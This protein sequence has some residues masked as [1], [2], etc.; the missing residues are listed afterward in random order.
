MT[1]NQIKT[2]FDQAEAELL[3]VFSRIEKTEEKNLARVLEAF[4]SQRIA[5][6]H[7]AATNGYGNGDI[8]RDGLEKVFAQAFGTQA[9]LVRPMFASGT[10]ALA[11]CLFGLLRPG[12]TMLAVSGRPYDTLESVIGLN[13]NEHGQGSLKEL[14]VR[15]RELKLLDS[16]VDFAALEEELKEKTLRLCHIQR[17]CGYAWRPAL[18]VDEIG[19]IAAFIHECRPDVCVMV[20]N[21]YG[22]FVEEKE[23][24]QVGAD[25]M[26]GS[27]IKN[28]GGGIAPTGGYIAGKAEL[29]E[30]CA[31]RLTAPG[32]GTELGSYA[33][34]YEPFYQGFFLAPHVVAQAVRGAALAGCVF[35]KLGFAV[36]PQ[37]DRPR[38]DIIQAIRFGNE[39]TLIRFCRAIQHASPIDSFVVPEPW[40]MAGY[41]DKV[42]MAAGTFVSGASIELSA[43]APLREPYIGYLQGGLSY[44]H[45]KFALMEAVKSLF[46]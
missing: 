16:G 32:I 39:E 15:Y 42:I 7:F 33:A 2:I 3:P 43:D 30:R 29:V 9:A 12:D 25:I 44:A 6:Q 23:P 22:E 37:P 4:R 21:C 19:R 26:A 17:S 11:V 10:H 18:R 46:A 45:V 13:E 34:G 38:S 8:G 28:P 20:D 27:L 41:Q 24:T 40:D 5:V 14:G 31:Y 35:Q 36:S 1:E